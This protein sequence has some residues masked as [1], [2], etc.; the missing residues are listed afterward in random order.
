M[1][2]KWKK[3]VPNDSR[4]PKHSQ[5]SAFVLLLLSSGLSSEQ[6]CD[7]FLES[8]LSVI[9]LSWQL[10]SVFFYSA[11]SLALI[12]KKSDAFQCLLECKQSQWQKN[13]GTAWTFSAICIY[14][15]IYMHVY[16]YMTS[17]FVSSLKHR[18]MNA[19]W[20][21]TFVVMENV[22]TAW[23]GTSV[24]AILATISTRRGTSVRVRD[25][26]RDRRC[27]Q[28]VVSHIWV[29]DF[30]FK[31]YFSYRNGKAQL[32]ENK[33]YYVKYYVKKQQ[34]QQKS[35]FEKHYSGCKSS[36]HCNLQNTCK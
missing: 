15:S 4:N 14:V 8:S 29:C 7:F 32:L 21:E 1:K 24:T 34:R 11:L 18:Q 33:N 10:Q 35:L 36:T 28:R 9:S 5:G 6:M 17:F 13:V 16:I 25:N 3:N 31:Q 12:W 23:P 26:G 30:F 20:A 27:Q 2:W 22:R 19:G